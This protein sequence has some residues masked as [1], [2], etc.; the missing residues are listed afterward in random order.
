MTGYVLP[1]PTRSH[2]GEDTAKANKHNEHEYRWC[3]LG[4][5]AIIAKQRKTKKDSG[6]IG[7]QPIYPKL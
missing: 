6:L 2:A 3:F 1:E 5:D 4:I 7:A